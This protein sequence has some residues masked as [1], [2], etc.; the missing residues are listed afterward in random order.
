MDGPHRMLG[1]IADGVLG[2]A[3]S[4]VHSA[5][6]TMKG[7]GGEVSRGLDKPFTE[8]TGLEGPH[9]IVDQVANGVIDSGV[10]FVDQGV[11]GSIQSLG[12]SAMAALDHPLKQ[13][14]QPGK[15]FSGLRK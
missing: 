9:R 2:G 5:A 15:I 1:S 6:N 8:I 14:G 12:N 13:I 3:R 4:F 7:A 10:N 11:L